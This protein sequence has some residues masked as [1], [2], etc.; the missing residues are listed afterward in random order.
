V[1]KIMSFFV[2]AGLLLVGTGCSTPPGGAAAVV[3]NQ[4]ISDAV[5][6]KTS[7]ILA[8]YLYDEYVAQREA[9]ESGEYTDESE[10]AQANE[11][12]G[13]DVTDDFPEIDFTDEGLEANPN[14]DIASP[15]ENDAF[16]GEGRDNTNEELSTDDL[17]FQD[18]VVSML[19]GTLDS[20]IVGA[21]LGQAFAEV[22]V[23]FSDE[24]KDRWVMYVEPEFIQRCWDDPVCREGLD[25][26]V[27]QQLAFEYI[28][29]EPMDFEKFDAALDNMS[30]WMN[31]R[32][33]QWDPQQLN[34]S[35]FLDKRPGGILAE[36]LL[37]TPP[38]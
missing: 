37:L 34:S 20:Q 6:Q 2:G 16:T 23:V 13:A 25:G 3:N 7:L 28:N 9:G 24:D 18:L 17:D 12:L 15:E 11:S 1:K 38:A 29:T 14:E 36:T 26:Y 32:Y 27:T 8:E 19:Q 35:A 33:G 10:P 22:D 21:I 30:V 31:P 5:V 4:V